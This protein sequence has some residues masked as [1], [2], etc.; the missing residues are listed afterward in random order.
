MNELNGLSAKLVAVAEALEVRAMR[1]AR[2]AL[3]AADVWKPYGPCN[4]AEL[5]E[6]VG[7]LI[8]SLDAAEVVQVVAVL[9]GAAPDPL[10]AVAVAAVA[11][12]V[13]DAVTAVSLDVLYAEDLRCL[14]MAVQTVRGA[15][16]EHDGATTAR[17]LR[18]LIGEPPLEVGAPFEE[19]AKFDDLARLSD[20]SMQRHCHAN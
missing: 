9:R 13:G 2:D 18:A 3:K 4:P 12:G 10:M 19:G 14:R 15:A 17:A 11:D 5:M 8:E 1:V 6:R 16:M 7:G 20:Y